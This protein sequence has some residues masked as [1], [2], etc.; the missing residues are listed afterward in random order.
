MFTDM[1]ICRCAIMLIRLH[2]CILYNALMWGEGGI[3]TPQMNLISYSVA[4]TSLGPAG[5]TPNSNIKTCP[6]ASS[7]NVGT[8]LGS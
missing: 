7:M 5:H 6:T 2:E 3:R 8:Q 4:P 1:Y